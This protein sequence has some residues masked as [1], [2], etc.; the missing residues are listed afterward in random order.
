MLPMTSSATAP[1]RRTETLRRIPLLRAALPPGELDALDTL[2]IWRRAADG[3]VLVGHEEAGRDVFF[4]CAGRVRVLRRPEP[5]RRFILTE[6]DAGGFFGELAAID[7]GV[8][9]ASVE[10]AGPATLA[11][12]PGHVFLDLCFR[13]RP[14][15]EALLHRLASE[16]RRLAAQVEEV[17]ARP[18]RQRIRAELLRLARPDGAGGGVISP[19][20]TGAE[21]AARVASQREVVSR[22]CRALERA[23]LLRRRRGA[24]ELPNLAA[25]RRGEE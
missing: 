3:E 12:M 17:A 15:G 22:E 23:G 9:S 16:I 5:G 8:R 14:M 18:A 7:G 4:V 20:P 24:I 1:H 21:I 19:P 6:I 2:C 10:A 11:R 25:L 13:H